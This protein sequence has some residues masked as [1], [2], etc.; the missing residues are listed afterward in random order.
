VEGREGRRWGGG[1]DEVGRRERG[2]GGKGERGE[3]RMEKFQ[4]IVREVFFF[5]KIDLKFSFQ[6]FLKP[7]KALFAFF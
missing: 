4:M 5:K 2:G 1:G 6:H 3:G 7:E